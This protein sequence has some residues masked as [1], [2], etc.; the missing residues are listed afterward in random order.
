MDKSKELSDGYHAETQSD[1][2]V[3]AQDEGW[4]DPRVKQIKRKVDIRLSAMLAL[5]YIVNQIDRNNLPNAVIAGM[6]DDLNL[7]G[8][9]Y[10]VIVLVFFP[11]YVLFNFVATVL[12][13]KLG[14][15]PFLAGITLAFGLVVVGFGL[16][17]TWTPL[18]ALRV[19]LGMFES[20]FF[21]SAIFL[22]AMWYTRREVAKRNAF[23]YLV[24]NSVGGFGGVLAYGLQQMDGIAGRP[25]WQWIFIWE[26]IM[27]VII[28]ALGYLFLIDFPEEAYRTKWFLKEDEI[29]I[30]IDRVQRD[31]ADAHVTPF[32]L[33]NYLSQ[34]KDWKIWLFGINFGMSGAV[35]YAVSYFLPIILRDSLGFTV[36]QSQCL[37]APC[38]AFSFLLGFATSWV[39]DKYNIRGHVLIFNALLEIIGVAVLGYAEQP[40]VRYFGAFLITAGCNSNVPASMTYQANNVVGQWKRAFTS[41]TIVAWGGI[42]GVIGTVA[43][44]SQDSPTYRPGLYTCFTCA[45]VTILSVATTTVYM[46]HKNRQQAK[47][48]IIIEGVPGFR[49]TL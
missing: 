19:L 36:V 40:Y 18:I 38:Y 31:R 44:R 45:S 28:A 46:W 26:G 42:G 4:E 23:F 21:P 15:R 5:M 47:G 49:Y 20:C 22:V 1:D 17:E 27:T 24:G 16:V 12:A 48:L 9:R 10:Q 41:A 30:M 33:K 37:T 2:V 32:N 8:N 14:P 11:T 3:V 35:T 34:A 43:F 39:S 29:K 13:R 6:D 25:G 7:I